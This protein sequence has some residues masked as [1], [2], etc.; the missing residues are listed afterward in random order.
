MGTFLLRQNTVSQ[1]YVRV[2]D[3]F[4]LTDGALNV[5]QVS[6]A[7]AALLG[8]SDADVGR[9][10]A[11]LPG[12]VDGEALAADAR[13]ALR[14]HVLVERE[15]R[16]PDGRSVAVQIHPDWSAGERAGVVLSF[17]EALRASDEHLRLMIENATDYAIFSMDL[18]RRIT[19]WNVGAERLLGYAEAEIMGQSADIIFTWQDRAAGAPRQES[20]AALSEGRA[21][22]DRFH[23][24]QDGSRF[25]AS[26]VMMRMCDARGQVIGLVK[27]LRD[28][29]QVREAQQA[30]ERSQAE[31][32]AAD[33][34]KDRFLAVLSHE[35]R[36]PLASIDSAASLL[37]T[38]G[39]PS[40]DRSEA[41]QV[42]K[43]QAGSMKALLDDLL[44]VSRLKLGRLELRRE[45]IVL[46]DVI[47]SALESVR[48]LLESAG[49]RLKVDLP[50][51]AIELDGDPLRLGQVLSNLLANSIKYTPAQGVIEMQASIEDGRAVVRVRDNGMG[52]DP[53]RIDRMFEMFEQ[54][55]PVAGRSQGL[56]IGLALA[57]S[58]VELHG[59]RIE[60]GSGGAGQGSEFR[61]LLPATRADVAAEPAAAPAPTPVVKKRGLILIA[62]DNIDAG[63]GIARLLEIAG[64]STLRVRGG[65]E[66]VKETRRHKPDVAIV[67]IGMP[68]LSGHEVARQIRA[69]AWG[70]HMVLIAATGWGQDSDE[71]DAAAAGFDAHMTKP[72]DLRKLSALVDDLLAQKRA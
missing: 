28:Q 6:P 58:I 26:G 55:Q 39:I 68:D 14:D 70:R 64:F 22:D 63:W 17:S 48:P 59:G 7:A 49:H 38:Q 54:A 44:D 1:P 9:P 23:E 31:L 43:R 42:V 67:D 21:S 41:A 24:R 56:G 2:L 53:Q 61:V 4:L 10:L 35:L 11:E 29:T 13:R 71:R 34:A 65:L 57:K 30:L 33:A 40:A 5:A 47:E 12:R 15:M 37:L 60:A 16:L 19:S 50:A 66:A 36:N 69:T 18:D 25:W 3:A 46:A 62:D 8:L 72:V 45:R 20:D 32:Q 27:I 51:Y 52:M